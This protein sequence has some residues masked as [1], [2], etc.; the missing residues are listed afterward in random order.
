ME[1]IGKADV[2]VGEALLDHAA[3]VSADVAVIGA[4]SH[5]RL[6][7]IVLGGVIRTM[8]QQMTLPMLMSH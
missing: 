2:S 8:L 4:Y 5:S 3:D 1:R 6:R 7:E